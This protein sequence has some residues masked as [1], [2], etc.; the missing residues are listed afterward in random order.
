M[1]Q[2]KHEE[3]KLIIQ[4]MLNAFKELPEEG[5]SWFLWDADDG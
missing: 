3:K 4:S 2:L 1:T 5:I